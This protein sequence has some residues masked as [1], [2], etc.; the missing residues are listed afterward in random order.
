MKFYSLRLLIAVILSV[1]AFSLP[2][3][4]Q[5]TAF[6]YQGR[7]D[8]NGAPATGSYDLRFGL[9]A[10]SSDGAAVATL[11]TNGSVAVSSG[12]FSTT[13]DFGNVF[14]GTNYFLEIG[15]RAGGTSGAFTTLTPRQT[16]TPTPYA[17]YA[18]TAGGITGVLSA[19]NLPPNVALLNNANFTG[20]ITGTGLNLG[21]NALIAPLTVTPRVPGAA[22]GSVTTLAQPLSLAI[23]GRYV[24]V[25]DA[26][27]NALQI[28][29]ASNPA[30]PVVVGSAT[31]GAFPVSVAMAGRFAYVVNYTDS[32]LQVFDIGN[33]SGP[34][35]VSTVAT[36]NKP[37]SVAVSGRYVYVAS[38]GANTL[39]AFDVTN[40]TKPVSVGTAATAA[41]PISVAIE[42]RY[43]YVG[44]FTAN[45]LQVFDLNN[46]ASPALVGSVAAGSGASSSVAVTGRY[47]IVANTNS[48]QIFDV[49]NPASPSLAGSISAVGG[50]RF[51]ALAGR[52]VYVANE[53]GTAN[54]LQV[55][56]ISNPASPVLLG[57]APT[58][59]SPAGITVS[60]RYV[61]VVDYN[62][63]LLQIFDLGGAFLQQLEAGSI[64]TGTLQIADAATVGNS[65]NV[66]GGFTASGSARISGGLSVDNGKITGDGSGLSNL[67]FTSTTATAITNF[68]G[69]LQGDVTGTQS[70]TVVSTVGGTSAAGIASGA[71]AANAAT[72][73]NTPGA[74]VSRD[75]SGNFSAGTITGAFNGDGS[76]LANLNAANLTGTLPNTALS[77]T[78]ANPLQLTNTNNVVAGTFIGNGAALSNLSIATGTVANFSGPLAGDVTGSQSSTVVSKVGGVSAIGVALGASAALSAGSANSPNTIV[79][80]DGTGSFSASNV[81]GSFTGDGSGLPNL[82]ATTLTGTVPNASLS[83]AYSNSL[84]LT[85][86]ANIISG[87]FAGNGA[88][89][90][91]LN[92]SVTAATATNFTGALVGDVTGTQTATVVGT[93]GGVSA[94]NVAG[95]A[96]AANAAT[97]ANTPGTLIKRDSSGNFSAGTITGNGAGLVNLNAANLTGTIPSASIAPGSIG[98]G[99]LANSSFVVSPGNG[100]IGG[101]PVALG[102]SVTVGTTATSV[103]SPG[104]IVSRDGTGSFTAGTVTGS[105]TGNGAGLVNLNATNLTGTLPNAAL[106]GTYSSTVQL[107]N[108]TNLIAGTFTGNGA[109]LTNLSMSVTA[110]TATNFTGVLAGDVTGTQS[111]TVVSKVGGVSAIGVAMGAS[112]ALGAG[113]ANSPN[114]IVKRDATGSFSAG[115]VTG[116]FSGDGSGLTNV[117]AANLTG[118]IPKGALSGAYSNALSLTNSTNVIA[119]TFTGNGA[120][121]TNLSI[122]TP[123]TATNFS[124]ALAGDVTGTQGVTVVAKVGGVTAAN[125]ATGANAANTATSINTPSTI[126]SRDALGGFAGNQISGGTVTGAFVGNGSGIVNLNA[127]NLTGTI[128]PATIATGSI[129][130][131]QLASSGLTIATA[132]GLTGGGSVPLGGTTTLGTTATPANTPN[133]IVSRDASGNFIAG[134][135]TGAFVGNGSGLTNLSAANLGGSVPAGALSGT[136][137]NAL[138]LTNATNL[139]AGTFTGNG[140]G[141]SNLSIAT[142]A[143]ATNF[144][145][146]LAGDVTGTQGATVVAKVGPLAAATVANG[147]SIAL[148]ATNASVPGT[149]VLRDNT[150]SF[151]A[152]TVTGSFVGSGAGLV[153]VSA[154]VATNFSGSLAGDVTGTQGA[155]VVA[156]VGGLTAAAVSTAV[157]EVAN[158]TGAATPSQLVLRDN[159]GSFSAANITASF[160]GNGNGLTNLNA[161]NLVGAIPKGALSGVYSNALSLTNATNVIAGTFTG[162]GAGLTGL[163]AANLTG[164]IPSTDIGPG[165]ISNSQ[166]ASNT[167]TIVPGNGVA[168][169]GTVPLGGALTLNTTATPNISV[170]TIVSRDATGSFTA[171]SVTL[172]GNLNLTTPTATSGMITSG[173]N[174]LLFA[175]GSQNFF[176]GPAAGNVTLSTTAATGV[177]TFALHSITTGVN[178]TAVGQDALGLN[179]SGQNNTATGAGA[180]GSN[181]TGEENTA[182]GTYS[183]EVNTTGNFNT[184]SGVSAMQ[185]NTTG[186]QNAAFGGSA[187]MNNNGNFNTAVGFA[188][189][190]SNTTGFGNIFLGY[191]AGESANP[192]GANQF[193]AGSSAAPVANVYLGNGVSNG[194]PVGVAINASSGSG[195]NVGGASLTLAGGASTGQGAGGPVIFLTA[196]SNSVSGAAG[197]PPTERMR[198]TS[199]GNVGIGKANPATALDVNGTVTATQFVGNGAGLTN[200]PAVSNVISATN[201][202]GALAGDVTGTQGATVVAKVGGVTAANVANG[203]N[204]ANAATSAVVP[205]T[206]VSRDG[207]GSFSATT[208]TG[209]FVGSGAGLINVTAN[210]ATN[211]SGSLSG[212]VTGTQA[213]T[214]V[215]KVGGVPA[216][217]VAGAV[218]EI[219]TATTAA[220]PNSIV[221]RDAAGGFSAAAITATFTGNGGGLTNLNATNLI[222]IIPA[223]ALSGTY[224]NALSLSYATNLIAG[225]FTGNGAG[226]ANLNVATNTVANFSG[227][228]AG[229]VTG[230]QGAT[231]VSRV[232]ALLA[233][234]VANGAS[235]ALSATNAPVPGTAVLRD[236]TGSFSAGTVTAAFVGNGAG[237][238]NLTAANLTGSIPAGALAG[239]YSNAVALTNPANLVFGKFMGDGAN[240]TNLPIVNNA[241][242]FTGALAGDVTGTQGATVV[243]KVGGV[244]AANVASGANAANGAT[245][246]NTGSAIVSRDATGSF[247]ASTITS[248]FVGNGAGITNFTAANLIGSIPAGALAGTYSN[249]VALT[250]MANLVFG[251]FMGDGANLTN[252]PIVN[253][254][255]NATNFSGTLSGDVT[256]TQGA[257]VVNKVGGVPAANVAGA[258]AE[259]SSATT[260]A[261][262]NSIVLRDAAGGFSA[263][264][265]TAT[266]TG[267]GGGVTNLNA[268]NLIGSIPAGALS[269]TY[270]NAVALTNPANLVF[271]KFMGDGANLTNLPIVN[272]AVNATNFSGTLSGDVT[273]TQGATVVAKVGGVTA[274][275]VASGANAANA[276]SSLDT[277]STIVTRDASGNFSAGVVTGSFVGN[278]AGLTSLSAGNLTGIIPSTTIA[279]GS[280]GNAQ[281]MNSSITL[282][283]GNGVATA[284]TVALGGSLTLNT[285]A[286][287]LN[288]SGAIVS[289]DGTGSFSAGT[290]TAAFV[291]NGGG[292]TNLNATN[293][294]GSIPAGAL[295]GTYSNAGCL[296]Q[297]GQP[298][299]RQVHGRRRRI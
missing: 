194:A 214:V 69:P 254:A 111:S 177:G 42:G 293:L 138:S 113:N 30:G 58:S 41:G 14:S 7:L 55:F 85:N 136:Y 38:F 129:Q 166:L 150:G 278:G 68:T 126:V 222:G 34:V 132:A 117:N 160:I 80:R 187:L 216:A 294:I 256:G 259:I 169:G 61:Y 120:G 248:S 54:G 6:T 238:T 215:S 57:S 192:A 5:S 191:N 252:L 250:N 152:G 104:A 103:N 212:D 190:S 226:L 155:T 199:L 66:R 139:I 206:I 90:T 37:Y 95:A 71:N 282:I 279:A 200:L 219:S 164:T 53:G 72:S 195:A 106:S 277:P 174:S 237:I 273:G 43:A 266:F 31:T 163:S 40:P 119:G 186:T 105:F 171:N 109:G 70:A 167:I 125:V 133:A 208:I 19:N 209:S 52:Y 292:V 21:S 59:S 157:T 51:A 189:G 26:N 107:T 290:V 299:L 48:L 1:L 265:I 122:A 261:T 124:G 168:S 217:N 270:S 283:P 291:G 224:S 180:L 286:T 253:N 140:A 56:D 236:N 210:S 93:V 297:P 146:T 121:L 101:G 289:R 89:L 4:A 201:F 232:G 178:D 9:F 165:S 98:N 202:S 39:Q 60:G 221:L 102:G 91:N 162:S 116:S 271:G 153:N 15:V 65:L 280:L 244:P 246:A 287:S 203:A 235:I 74:I 112:A 10:A 97:S 284:G 267:N 87:T 18:P 281:L 181:T 229:D 240:L 114:T 141:L 156:K 145:G 213:A 262:P 197:N 176:A 44:N 35:A 128:P 79:K 131:A 78:Y 92:M 230:T 193:I 241:V 275:N 63:N 258:V 184:A 257:T 49:K 205:S 3:F 268:T 231:V 242:N 94:A 233:P 249:A 115:T 24:A 245:S 276:A 296:D 64:E 196:P 251:K 298:G 67:V 260:A 108:A 84:Q 142:S 288:N 50:P 207:N 23:Q 45:S 86:T 158:A 285:T 77:G 179:T 151:S 263:A 211:F 234:M 227:A 159:T 185:N 110:A 247:S 20:T 8:A 76:G 33:P 130:N 188:A 198:I 29:D 137:S 100:V 127:G 75:G 83:G 88:G 269:G 154:N 225:T 27:G 25:V 274:A 243:S 32:T 82:K 172:A 161:T 144:S 96:N 73:A 134:T 218:T 118:I 28:V 295:S 264:A 182:T 239:T 148:T 22:V 272:N 11:V 123:V 204:A 135:V 183:L 46:P 13:L 62:A 36:G 149:V 17:L 12:M 99:Q 143:T 223:G 2:V 170:N 81:A 16:I 220:T 173:G 228:L 147:A 255:V 47:A 175:P